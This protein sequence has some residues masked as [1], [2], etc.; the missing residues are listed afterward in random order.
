MIFAIAATSLDNVVPKESFHDLRCLRAT[1]KVFFDPWNISVC[2]N[3][4]W[5]T[6]AAVSGAGQKIVAPEVLRILRPDF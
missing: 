5:P 3:I 2:A 4:L 1:S 6:R